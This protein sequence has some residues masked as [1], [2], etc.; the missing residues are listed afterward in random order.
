MPKSDLLPLFSKYVDIINQMPKEFDSHEFILR[1][2][3]GYQAEYVEALYAYRASRHLKKAAP[4]KAVH[5]MLASQLGEHPA[6]IEQVGVEMGVDIFGQ[7][8]R[9]TKWR[10]V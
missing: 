4:F 9:A 2:A 7:P 5:T 8:S 3:R 1:L 10:K 6:L